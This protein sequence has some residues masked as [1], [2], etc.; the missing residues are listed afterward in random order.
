MKSSE[1]ILMISFPV[2]TVVVIMVMMFSFRENNSAAGYVTVA[3]CM[4]VMNIILFALLKYVSQ[5]EYEYTQLQLLQEKNKEK[6]QSYYGGREDYNQKKRMLHDYNNQVQCIRG[7]LQ[8]KKYKEAENYAGK[9][10][11]TLLDGSEVVD[12]NNS[13]INVV[14]NQKYRLAK[15]K[16]ITVSFQ[17]NDLSGAWMEE[18]DMVILLANLL[19]NAIEACE[20]RKDDPVIR[21][22]LLR[23]NSQI[24][25]SVQNPVEST[26]DMIHDQL[27]TSK[28]DKANHGIGLKNVQMVLEKYDGMSRIH[29]EDGW[30]YFTAMIPDEK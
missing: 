9:L 6:M 24:L 8:Q 11:Q 12:V 13:V 26:Q 1:W 21:L 20:N 27:S 18:Q 10:T 25:L 29:S 2:L 23:E 5:R 16:G 7:L 22:K 19:D 28:A 14:L 3:L 30:F 15:S 17:I 4:A